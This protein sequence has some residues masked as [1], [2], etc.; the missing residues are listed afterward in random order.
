MPFETTATVRNSISGRCYCGAHVFTA[1]RQPDVV[2]YC[3]CDDCRRVSGAPVAAFAAFGIDNITFNPPLET[4][5]SVT[6]GVER[7]F[8]KSC[9]S[10]LAAT[11]AYLPDQLYVSLGVID[12][13]E[14]LQPERHAHAGNTLAWLKIDDDLPRDCASA[15]QALMRAQDK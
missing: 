10:P 13:A 1:T 6:D 11:Y 2:T 14:A 5:I 4:S 8:C 15:R 9:G 12:Q 7:W 3:H